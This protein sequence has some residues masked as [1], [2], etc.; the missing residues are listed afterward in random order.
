MAA[1]FNLTAQQGPEI[2]LASVNT[3]LGQFQPITLLLLTVVVSTLL[4]SIFPRVNFIISSFF[5]SVVLTE[6]ISMYRR[7][8][9]NME[10][11]TQTFYLTGASF[12]LASFLVSV[13]RVFL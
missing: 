12:A 7:D 4:A 6:L 5:L 8:Y 9:Q 2:I 11:T 1:L 13:I 3:Y 10:L